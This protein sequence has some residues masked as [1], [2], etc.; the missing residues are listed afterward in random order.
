MDRLMKAYDEFFS[1]RVLT[2]HPVYYDFVAN[3]CKGRCLD[4][5]CANGGWLLERVPSA[6][7][8]DFSIV[9]IRQVHSKGLTALVGDAHRLPFR[10]GAFDTVVSLGS[11]EHFADPNS[12]LSEMSRVLKQGGHLFL[13]VNPK[14]NIAFALLERML[15][16]WGR[17]RAKNYLL[18][19]TDSRLSAEKVTAQ[20]KLH[21]LR[22][23]FEGSYSRMVLN[24]GRFHRLAKKVLPFG[25][26]AAPCAHL[27]F[28]QKGDFDERDDYGPY[29]PR[30]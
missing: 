6:I 25:W 15:L 5:A 16:A 30:R 11:L 17:L 28:C 19:P 7:G 26:R 23:I 12:S 4:I 10:S 20:L 27:F 24:F 13:T 21:G 3:F 29:F 14:V 8:L 9:A 2:E 1:Q 22:I 18:Q